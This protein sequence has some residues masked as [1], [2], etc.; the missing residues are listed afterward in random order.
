MGVRRSK[1][2]QN[3]VSLKTE[4]GELLRNESDA[5]VKRDRRWYIADCL[6]IPGANGLGETKAAA[7]K[8]RSNAIAL[9]LED[10]R[11]DGLRGILT[12]ATREKVVVG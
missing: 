9:I 10:R 2:R 11:R 6:E 4:A 7:L 5:V 8:N 1:R 12:G 3:F